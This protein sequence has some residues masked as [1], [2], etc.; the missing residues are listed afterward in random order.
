ML[1]TRAV[2]TIKN[3]KKVIIFGKD[4]QLGFDLTR[5][6]KDF[7]KVIALN[8]Q[9]VDIINIHALNNVIR[10]EK[11]FIV[12]NATAYNKVEQAE[13]AKDLAFSINRT[14]VGNLAKICKDNNVIFIHV[15]TD[16]VFDGSKE[17]FTEQDLPNP[18]NTYGASKLAGEELVKASGVKYYLIRTSSVFGISQSSQKMN[19]VDKMIALAKEGKKLKIVND[20]SMSPTY[21]L[22]LALKIKELIEKPAPFGLYHITNQGSCSWYELAKKSLELMK[23]NVKIEPIT[24]EDSGSQVKR[25][26]QSILKNLALENLGMKPMPTWQDALSRY[27]KEKYYI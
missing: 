1:T 12:I 7:Y 15:S 20:Q 21:S 2:P 24:S 4:G 10:K 6:L 19:F 26:K 25:P 22:D 11:P 3:M 23:L 5:E 13:V 9:R 17:F 16:Y 8:H 18:L 14:A 27:L